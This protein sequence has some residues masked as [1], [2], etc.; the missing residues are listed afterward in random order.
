MHQ[1]YA[2]RAK[3]GY[4]RVLF[5]FWTRV[6]YYLLS[7]QLTFKKFRL[8]DTSHGLQQILVYDVHC[9]LAGIFIRKDRSPAF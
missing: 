8:L 7:V 2:E 4:Q 5:G 9:L 6:V 1:K 3:S